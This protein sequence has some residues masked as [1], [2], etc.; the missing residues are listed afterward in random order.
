MSQQV[1]VIADSTCYLPPG[2][3]ADLGIAIVPVQVIVGG[4]A[5]DETEDDQAQ[6]VAEALRDWQP[7]TTSRPSPLRFLQAYREAEE[8]GAREIVVATLSASMSATYESAVL[9]AK[10]FDLPVHVVDSPHHRDGPGL[11]RCE[12]CARRAR[13]GRRHDRRRRSSSRGRSAS[14]VYFYVDT[15]EYLRRGGRVSAARAA[16]GQALQVKPLL[17]R[18]RRARGAARAGPHR[19]PGAGAGSRTSRSRPPTGCDVDVAVQHLA[20]PD[21]AATLAAHLRERLPAADVVEGVVGG[22]VG[23]HVGPGHG[24]GGRRPAPA[25]RPT[26]V[27]MSGLTELPALSPGGSIA[28]VVGL[29]ARR[30]QPG[31]HRRA[32]LRR[33]PAPHGLG[34]PRGHER[35]PGARAAVGG[36]RRRP[37]RPQGL[38]P[39]VRLRRARR[40]RRPARSP[41][42]RP[43]SATSPR[44]TSRA[45]RQGRGHDPRR[46]PR[47]AAAAGHPRADRLRHRRGDLA[48]GGPGR[49]PRGGRPHRQRGRRLVRPAGRT[50]PTCGSPSCWASLVLV[51]H[52]RNIARPGRPSG[53]RSRRPQPSVALAV[54]HGAGDDPRPDRPADL[55]SGHGVGTT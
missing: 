18:R 11:R 48:P 30:R 6:R 39:R 36:A 7:V 52:Q 35:H 20:S 15:L 46:D 5:F 31:R 3:A 34:Q 4:Q 41:A 19:G 16:V 9:A 32:G 13:R 21:R 17:T 33:R 44:R 55:A 45:R 22:V 27:R 50:S 42:S 29:R 40:A 43:S 37:R 47:R 10:E 51:R 14:A 1:A 8:A 23:A 2:W 12:R 49:R 26:D 24:G 38:R 25:R 28:A 54:V 53:T